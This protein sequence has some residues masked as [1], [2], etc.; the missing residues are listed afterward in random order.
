MIRIWLP[1]LLRRQPARL[2][3]AA[4]GVAIAVALLASLGA[5]L[6]HAK[7]SMTARAVRSVSVDWQVQVAAGTD[8]A[9]VASVI[10][11]QPG[12]RAGLPVGFTRVP[13]LSATSTGTTQTTGAAVVLGL[14][15]NYQATFPGEIRSLTGSNHGVLVAQQ[16]ASNL[17]AVPGSVIAIRRPDWRRSPSS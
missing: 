7:A 10:T 3:G 8:P 17:H 6:A 2:L 4:T 5:F 12:V 13:G 15:P 14:P 11:H 9:A 16:T 1:A